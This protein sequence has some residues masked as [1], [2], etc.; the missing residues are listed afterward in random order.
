M[1]SSKK[2]PVTLI[3]SDDKGVNWTSCELD[4]IYNAEDYYVDF[5]MRIRV[6]LYVVMPG[7]IMKRSLT[8]YTRQLMVARRGQQ[9][10]AVLLIIY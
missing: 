6:L 10:E 7:L 3:Y 4:N 2:V 5:L 8:G 9:L 1:G